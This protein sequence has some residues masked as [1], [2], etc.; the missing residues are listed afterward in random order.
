MKKYE[1][2]KN[3]LLFTFIF[4]LFFRFLLYIL[5]IYIRDIYIIII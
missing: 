4:L 1:K 5:K 2:I 3:S